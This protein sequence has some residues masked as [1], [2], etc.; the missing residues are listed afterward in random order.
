M[1]HS[2][3]Q[4]MAGTEHPWI[5]TDSYNTYRLHLKSRH[6]DLSNNGW[7]DAYFT[8]KF[9]SHGFR[10][11]EFSDKPSIV[12]LGCS[13]T[14]GVGLPIYETWP[15]IVSKSLNLECYNLGIPGGANDTSFRLAYYWLKRIKPDLVI[16]CQI[17]SARLELIQDNEIVRLNQSALARPDAKQVY[18]DFYKCWLST[19]CNLELNKEKN[20]LAITQ[21]CA[22]L[23]IDLE[24]FD[25][26]FF[27]D[28]KV[29]LARDLMHAGTVTN[30]NFSDYVLSNLKKG[31]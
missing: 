12:F 9:N 21:I 3:Y 14:F 15:Y 16:L 23:N 11:D 31:A 18:K 8:Y 2:L 19:E 5:P 13:H 7:I 4:S 27:V 10:C 1:D 30:K 29:D 24:I 26:S 25:S 6:N 20:I 22:N 17:N 28:S